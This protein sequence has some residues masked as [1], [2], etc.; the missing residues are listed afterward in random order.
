MVD[1]NFAKKTRRFI[2]YIFRQRI[3]DN[4]VNTEDVIYEFF[5][6]LG[7]AYGTAKS[8]TGIA[9]MSVMR[10]ELIMKSIIAIYGLVI[11]VLIAGGI[12]PASEGYKLYK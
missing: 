2:R 1:Y 12:N 11:A 10:P 3:F 9:A 4:G 7:A 5:S 6:A 8:G